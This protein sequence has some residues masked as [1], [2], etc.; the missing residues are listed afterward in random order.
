M[1]TTVIEDFFPCT[2]VWLQMVNNRDEGLCIYLLFSAYL[3]VETDESVI[4][5]VVYFQSFMC[6]SC[7][8]AIR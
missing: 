7:L 8:P 2:S 3:K 1:E 5:Y 4:L 6:G